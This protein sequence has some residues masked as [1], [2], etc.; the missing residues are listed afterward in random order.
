M[1]GSEDEIYLETTS[2]VIQSFNCCGNLQ[3][4]FSSIT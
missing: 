2:Y 3:L 4:D 1:L